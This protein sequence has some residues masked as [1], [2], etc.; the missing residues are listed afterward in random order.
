MIL[1][2]S[3][4]IGSGDWT[5]MLDGIAAALRDP[6]IFPY[7]SSVEL[8]VI[9]F[10]GDY[11]DGDNMAWVEVGPVVI[12]DTPSDPGYY[13]DIATDIQAIVQDD[14]RTPTYAGIELAQTTLEGS[15]NHPDNGGDFSRQVFN[16]VTDGAPNEYPPG[17][18]SGKEAAEAY[19]DVLVASL[20]SGEDEFDAEGVGISLSNIDWLKNEIVWPEPGYEAPPFDQGA[21]WVRSVS[22]YTEFAN[23]IGEKFQVILQSIVNCAEVTSD[24]DDLNPTDNIACVTIYPVNPPQP[25]T[26]ESSTMIFEGTLDQVVTGVYTGTIDAVAGYFYIPS[27]PGT[28]YDSTDDRYETPDDREAV[29]G[30]DVYAEEGG[31][32][33]YD[34]AVQG[35]IGSDHDAYSNAGGWGAFW[36]PDV[37]DW[38]H[39]QLT[40]TTDHWYLE[41]KG[42]ALG[43]PMSGAMSWVFVLEVP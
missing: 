4:S 18:S 27:G 7:D 33:Y 15:G 41:Y 1:D 30:F 26:V 14:D 23:T 8:T 19:R 13:D 17:Y 2:G 42:H 10:S 3:G 43:T 40:L 35:T 31:T 11:S 28:H 16:L 6:T 36:D 39:Y 24:E 9:Q 29:G 34:D 20:N 21:G 22:D 37:P 25:N 32:A 38:E 5:I 12:T